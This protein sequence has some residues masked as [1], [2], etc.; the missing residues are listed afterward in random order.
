MHAHGSLAA[1]V[2]TLPTRGSR[3]RIA[4]IGV[5]VLAL[6][7]SVGASAATADTTTPPSYVSSW[8]ALS[9]GTTSSIALVDSAGT[10]TATQTL[11]T[12]GTACAL[13]QGAKNLLE[14]TGTG[15]LGPGY[16]GSSIGVRE[17]KSAAGTSCSAVDTS[18]G[19]ALTLTR[20]SGVGGLLMASAS[21]DINLKQSSQILA[22]AKRGSATVGRYELRSGTSIS[23]P[24][25]LPG[26]PVPAANV[27]LCNNPADSGP[28]SG[29]NNNCRW[30][31]S[32]PS[33]TSLTEDG[34]VF[35]SLELK[36]V[37]GSFSLQGGADGV[38]DDPANPT[39]AYFGADRD[40]SLFELVEGTVACDEQVSLRTSAL[41]PTSTW[42]RL[43]NLD[44]AAC[45]AYPYS[46]STGAQGSGAFAR[47]TKPL[48][49]ET[50]SQAIWTTT[51]LIPGGTIPPVTI[52]LEE[53]A[54]P[55]TLLACPTSW[56]VDGVFQGP[57]SLPSEATACL[58]SVVKGKGGGSS[59]PVTFTVYVF[60]DAKLQW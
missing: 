56:Y 19:E 4:A 54:G 35:D 13:D 17:K 60:G 58:V 39:P 25:A 51:F 7:V 47:F 3:R 45:S 37:T 15:S 8:L 33:W 27:W 31:I 59:K 9:T 55:Q 10:T 57:T 50:G 44:G 48:D 6:G 1:P 38:V 11:A 46:T 32:A 30:Q 40:A 18:V 26:G 41:V 43:G 5:A 28:D 52:D 24:A 14:L 21:L 29:T 23:T 20:R 22:T 49:F 2:K 42:K 12:S 16:S 36:A 34:V 53:G